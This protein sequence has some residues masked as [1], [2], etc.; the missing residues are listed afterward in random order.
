MTYFDER[1]V[2]IGLEPI[3]LNRPLHTAVVTLIG[4]NQTKMAPEAMVANR[5][6]SVQTNEIRFMLPQGRPKINVRA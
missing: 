6:T 1:P 5:T 4:K 2:S 3:V